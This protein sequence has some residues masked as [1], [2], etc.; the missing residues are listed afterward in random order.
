MLIRR[1][2]CVWKRWRKHGGQT[3]M[4]ARLAGTSTANEGLNLAELEDQQKPAASST[5]GLFGIPPIRNVDEED[6][7]FVPHGMSTPPTGDVEASQPQNYFSKTWAMQRGV[8]VTEVSDTIYQSPTPLSIYVPF[9]RSSPQRIWLGARNLQSSIHVAERFK[10]M[11]LKVLS[12]AIANRHRKQ[13]YQSIPYS[14]LEWPSRRSK[15]LSDLARISADIIC[16]Q[17][18]DQFKDLEPHLSRRGY[19]SC[20]KAST[21]GASNGCAI[22]WKKG[23]FK[24]LHEESID[25]S[26]LDMRTNV[27]QLCILELIVPE[28]KDIGHANSRKVDDVR[29][30]HLLVGNINALFNPRRGDIKLGQCRVFLQQAQELMNEWPGAR[31]VIGGCFHA[32][33]QSAIYR[34]LTESKLDV[35]GLDYHFLSGHFEKS[36]AS[37]GSDVAQVTNTRAESAIDKDSRQEPHFVV[38]KTSTEESSLPVNDNESS[39]PVSCGSTEKDHSL[40]VDD[41]GRTIISSALVEL[42]QFLNAAGSVKE[43]NKAECTSKAVNVCEGTSE[44]VPASEES[45]A[46]MQNTPDESSVGSLESSSHSMISLQSSSC[47]EHGWDPESLQRATGFQDRTIVEVGLKLFSVYPEIMGELGTRDSKGEPCLTMAHG[48]FKGT[49]DY[50]LRS[51]GL[52]TLRV[53]DG[54][55][56]GQ[57]LSSPTLPFIMS[58]SDHISL[59]CELGFASS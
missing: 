55:S 18:L 19:H 38:Q 23:R 9:N 57:I 30:K 59:A 17:E 39:C 35:S 45:L 41:A 32:T 40:D 43:E 8:P 49:V 46:L 22:F 14:T 33:P 53:L 25:F 51:E 42:E 2:A 48:E 27:A 13:L 6:E 5:E 16:L 3:F 21:S 34:F 1:T 54:L 31:L 44:S 47:L 29:R 50:I 58:G 28:S 11:S 15:L 56:E 10:F 52:T 4:F 37:Q 26:P 24:L 36:S 12:T 20:Y 7:D